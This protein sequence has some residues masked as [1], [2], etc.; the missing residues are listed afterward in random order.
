[1]QILQ[2]AIPC[3]LPGYFDYLYTSTQT[4]LVQPGMRVRASF[5]KRE[6]VGVVMAIATR[7]E[8]PADKLKPIQSVLDQEPLWP[9][10]L[11]ELIQWAAR[12]YHYPIG[13]TVATA[14]PA[15]LLRG[16]LLPTVQAH[17][18]V[19]RA[20]AQVWQL[21][22]AG[23]A[24]DLDKLAQRA[25]KQARVLA[26][27]RQREHTLTTELRATLGQV[28][29]IVRELHN[30]GWLMPV[31]ASPSAIARDTHL[32]LNTEQAEAVTRLRAALHH[33]Q[34]FL[35]DGVTGSG[36]TEV[37]LQT[38]ADVLAQGRQ[39]LVLAPEINLTPQM[40]AR[41]RQRFGATVV[42]LHSRLN[43]GE[44]L[45]GWQAARSGA[46]GVIIGTRLAIWTPLA[47]PG[48][49]VVDE[50]HDSSYKQA[51]GLLYSA[52]DIAVLRGQLENIPVVLG[53]ATPSLESVYNARQ[54]R[55][56]LLRLTERAGNAKPPRFRMID[57]RPHRA[58][59]L[60]P[61][62]ISALRD[63]LARGE[64][65]LIFIN[66]RGYAPVYMCHACGWI[67]ECG[68]CDAYLTYHHSA[69]RL[70]C[71]HCGHQQAPPPS[72][73]NCGHGALN[74]VGFGSERIEL[75][76]REQFPHARVLRL[77]S[78]NTQRKHAMNE[79][80]ARIQEGDADILVGT[81]MLAKGHHFPKVTLVGVIN[82]DNGLFA[83]DFRASERLAQLLIQ[84]AGRA[85]R[86]EAPG[87][88]WLQTWH[89]DH[90]QL[91]L[92]TRRTYHD[93]ADVALQERAAAQLPPYT[94]LA[95]MRVE[96]MRQEQLDTFFNAVMPLLHAQPVLVDGL[97]QCSGPV[98]APMERRANRL[99]AQV[100]L[101]SR[102]R[103]ALQQL[104]HAWLPQCAALKKPRGLRW[105][106]DVDPLDL[107]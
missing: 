57:M 55:Y 29:A 107:Y 98:P 3:P 92:L 48:I 63:C 27:L 39:A 1:M 60:A 78:D 89:P 51:S 41:F 8:Q 87:E 40:L 91:A 100:L 30:K 47:R 54:G 12:Y 2:V 14:L 93:F 37:Y 70:Q 101:Q 24:E 105:A 68:H 76:M 50:E 32:A 11:L 42:A 49:I 99:R 22:A 10:H 106:I 75:A 65:A 74:L 25:P 61:A 9:P 26:Y 66:R 20:A 103:A 73:P 45:R 62:L 4:S 84:V 83:L 16:Q 67:A 31:P 33:F 5:G 34:V 102:K 71:H 96:A 72:C 97:A 64:Q 59:V 17:T 15:L 69:S 23:Q 44:R 79:A 7:S 77:D 86:A 35:L 43:D 58:A 56:S 52:R 19:D 95:L 81:Q 6:V 53:S 21:T 46:A 82:V 38:I 104:L 88:V 28:N 90:P 85:G 13:A 18:S 80:L 94:Y 36:K